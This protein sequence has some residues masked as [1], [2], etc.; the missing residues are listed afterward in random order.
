MGMG[1]VSAGG[2]AVRRLELDVFH[3][4]YWRWRTIEWVMKALKSRPAGC[5]AM[6]HAWMCKLM[7][8]HLRSDSA[9]LIV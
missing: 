5:A 4:C 9:S 7:T 3:F 8:A 6:R 2:A 1:V